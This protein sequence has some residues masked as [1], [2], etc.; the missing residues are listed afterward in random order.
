VE[1]N[2]QLVKAKH[3]RLEPGRLLV[4]LPHCLQVTECTRRITVNLSNCVRCGRC[5]VGGILDLC[6]RYGVH[7][8]IATGGT[9][10]RDAVRKLRP[11]AIVAV[12]CERDLTSGILDCIPLPVLGVTNERPNG[13]CFNTTVNL[14]AVEAA[15]LFFIKG[16]EKNVR[17]N[18]SS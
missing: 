7:V 8:C 17:L 6:E 4:L 9:L 11:Q 18:L 12:A 2:N 14:Q 3:G 5:P 15:I 13:P 1:V 10:A 16:G